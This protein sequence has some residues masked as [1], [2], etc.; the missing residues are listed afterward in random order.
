MS[1]AMAR[2][3]VPYP[4]QALERVPRKALRAAVAARR[5]LFH[6]LDDEA[7]A[8]AAGA[9]LE[10]EVELVLRQIGEP[11]RPPRGHHV[12][13][14][15]GD[16]IVTI[17]VDP[18]LASAALGKLLKRKPS[19]ERPGA[20]LDPA[21][22][23]ALSALVIEITRRVTIEPVHLSL[24]DAE[25]GASECSALIEASAIIDGRAFAIEVLLEL[26]PAPTTEP[27][28]VPPLASL[29]SLDVSVPLVVGQSLAQPSTLRML[30]PGGAWMPGEGLWIDRLGAG[31]G[32]L[33]APETELGIAVDLASDGGIMLRDQTIRLPLAPEEAAADMA[34]DQNTEQTIADV[35]LDTPIVVRVELGS[36]TLSARQWAEL[37]SGD[38]LETRR[39]VAEPVEL[40]VAGR[41]V[42]R[43]ELVDIEGE[44]GVRIRELVDGGER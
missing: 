24:S 34:Q 17:G 42:A 30:Q 15:L 31:Q 14:A 11:S 9:A 36:V 23:G 21:I 13:L 33:A 20:P 4:W 1:D 37:R 12:R 26:P 25:G 35:V 44:L 2:C 38:V 10:A 8:R 7:I 3:P 28:R 18:A 32:A 27:S 5:R 41:V 22:A 43:G 40:R 19:L 29:G 6:A 16:A 39:R